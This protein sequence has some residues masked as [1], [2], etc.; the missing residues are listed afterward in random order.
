[1]D[2]VATINKECNNNPASVVP[3]GETY[4]VVPQ[5]FTGGIA[6]KAK[7]TDWGEQISHNVSTTLPSSIT[8]QPGYSYTYTFN[9]RET[10][11]IVN[12]TKFTEQW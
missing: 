1:M 9:I 3:L 7:W 11:L 10:D 5:L 8:W 4:L 2:F 6:V 12:V